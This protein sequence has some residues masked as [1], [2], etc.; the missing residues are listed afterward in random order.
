[1]QSSRSHLYFV[2]NTHGGET[3]KRLPRVEKVLGI[4]TMEDLMEGNRARGQPP[5]TTATWP[6]TWR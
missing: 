1:M 6:P 2:T 5:S 4:V 3:R